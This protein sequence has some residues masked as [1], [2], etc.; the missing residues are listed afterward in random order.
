MNEKQYTNMQN[1]LIAGQTYEK[2]FMNSVVLLNATNVARSITRN[3]LNI[4]EENVGVQVVNL[5]TVD[6]SIVGNI[7]KLF[8]KRG[9]KNVKKTDWGNN[10]GYMVFDWRC[11]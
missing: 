3:I 1:A 11:N 8:I 9:G 10:I 2:L 4:M 5:E 7:T 6:K